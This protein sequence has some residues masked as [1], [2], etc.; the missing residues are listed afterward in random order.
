[1]RLPFHLPG[2]HFSRYSGIESQIDAESLC[3][4]AKSS[5]WT[6]LTTGMYQ[7]RA[8]GCRRH[9]C[10]HSTGKSPM[11]G[12]HLCHLLWVGQW[13]GQKGKI[14][15]SWLL[16]SP[17]TDLLHPISIFKRSIFKRDRWTNSKGLL[18]KRLWTG[19][20]TLLSKQSKHSRSPRYNFFFINFILNQMPCREEVIVMP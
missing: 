2:G 12:S 15:L 1:M 9:C 10:K 16:S 13:K 5:C 6:K 19:L 4:G 8:C 11:Q 3:K 18:H 14:E 7:Y 20:A 17:F